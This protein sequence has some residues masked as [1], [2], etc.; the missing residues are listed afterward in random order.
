MVT[1]CRTSRF[2]SNPAAI[3]LVLAFVNTFSVVA[4]DSAGNKSSP[5]TITLNLDCVF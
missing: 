5:A 4:V 3:A 1:N 2:A